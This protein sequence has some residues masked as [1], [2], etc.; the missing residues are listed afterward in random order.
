MQ[1]VTSISAQPGIYLRDLSNIEVWYPV[2][3]EQQKIIALL[4]N[5]CN[6]IAA[7]EQV[8]KLVIKIVKNFLANSLHLN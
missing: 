8:P 7:N 1:R 6:L 2:I 3:S 4:K 5:I